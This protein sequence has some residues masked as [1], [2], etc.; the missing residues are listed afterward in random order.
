MD[1]LQKLVELFTIFLIRLV[2]IYAAVEVVYD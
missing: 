2:T 1:E